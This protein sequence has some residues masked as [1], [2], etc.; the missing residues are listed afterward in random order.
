LTGVA[1]FFRP[2]ETAHVVTVAPVTIVGEAAPAIPIVRVEDLPQV[3]EHGR[4]IPTVRV[5]DLP[6]A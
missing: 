2:R 6:R 4:P 3:D 1:Q 5:E